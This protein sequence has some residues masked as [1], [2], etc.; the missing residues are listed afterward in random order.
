MFLGFET[1]DTTNSNSTRIKD[2][3]GEGGLGDPHG[4]GS[5]QLGGVLPPKPNGQVKM[6][7]RTF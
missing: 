4:F 1:T 3:V 6:I 5:Y 2:L 7:E